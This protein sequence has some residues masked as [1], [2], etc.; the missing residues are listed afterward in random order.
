[1]LN[2]LLAL[3][4]VYFGGGLFVIPFVLDR[5][6]DVNQTRSTNKHLRDLNA[7]FPMLPSRAEDSIADFDQYVHDHALVIVLAWPVF[8]FVLGPPF[9]WKSFRS[10]FRD[11]RRLVP[12]KRKR[13]RNV[14]RELQRRQR[15]FDR[16]LAAS[17]AK[18]VVARTTSTKTKEWVR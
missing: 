3:V 13:Q 6:Y 9:L 10:A 15:D 17:Q 12:R 1:M 11:I 5:K 14:V 16:R 7:A 4:G 8:V 2:A 18:A